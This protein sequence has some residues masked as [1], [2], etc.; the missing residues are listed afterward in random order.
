MM[1]CA[2]DTVQLQTSAAEKYRMLTVVAFNARTT[3]V[4]GVAGPS[5]AVFLFSSSSTVRVISSILTAPEAFSSLIPTCTSA[6]SRA[7]CSQSGM[8]RCRLAA[9]CFVRV[10]MQPLLLAVR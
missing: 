8:R 5:R 7:C 10:L 6:F 4:D 2:K 3:G 1:A 9:G